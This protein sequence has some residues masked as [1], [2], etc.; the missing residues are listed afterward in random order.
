MQDVELIYGGSAIG[1]TSTNKLRY[2]NL[3]AKYH[4]HDKIKEHAEAFVKSVNR[5]C[6]INCTVQS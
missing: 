6:S 5:A 1:V 3:V 2:I 4:L